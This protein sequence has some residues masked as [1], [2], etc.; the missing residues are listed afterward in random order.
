MFVGIPAMQP[1]AVNR[2]DQKMK[3]EMYNLEALLAEALVM[4]Q[5]NSGFVTTRHFHSNVRNVLR[6]SKDYSVS[7]IFNLLLF[8]GLYFC[9]SRNL[10][11]TVLM[12]NETPSVNTTHRIP[13]F[14]QTEYECFL[15]P[16]FVIELYC[17]CL[18]SSQDAG[19]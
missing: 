9:K 2:R 6:S 18:E 1:I 4:Y 15:H 12:C 13:Y 8:F 19:R 7:K 14:K 11:N 17:T 3:K 5:C 10:S 16:V